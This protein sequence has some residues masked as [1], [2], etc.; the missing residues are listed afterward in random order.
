MAAVSV[1]TGAAATSA[2]VVRSSPAR[3]A[4]VERP[5]PG[6]ALAGSGARNAS[7]CADVT[8]YTPSGLARDVAIRASRRLGPM[9]I[10]QRQPRVAAST[11]ARSASA[12]ATAGSSSHGGCTAG[13]GGTRP[14]TSSSASS[15]ESTSN[16]SDVATSA[17]SNAADAAAKASKSYGSTS[18]DGQSSFAVP[19][20][21]EARTPDERAS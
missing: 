3:I 19:T 20:N 13:A 7:A 15:T 11:R 10:E 18:S 6:S 16:A 5:T 8:R 1:L 12:K 21:M 14:V 9:P 4:A 17:E 2:T